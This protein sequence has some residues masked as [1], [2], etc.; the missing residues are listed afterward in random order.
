MSGDTTPALT[1][2]ALPL[3]TQLFRF[4]LTGGLSALVDFGLLVLLMRFGLDH[5]T[6]KALSFV[7]GTTTAY[8]INMRWTFQA[9][10]SK[11]TFAAV[12]L[13]YGITFAL[14]WGI[15]T[16]LYPWLVS[17]GLGE[18]FPPSMSWAQLLG[19]VVAQGVATTVN[20]IVQRTVI[21]K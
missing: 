19:F 18:E 9:E 7:A 10:G 15:F 11:R 8:L 2:T 6:A 12:V 21:F 20:F 16:P 17:L 1:T 5:A 13:L 4:V 14:Q 3:G